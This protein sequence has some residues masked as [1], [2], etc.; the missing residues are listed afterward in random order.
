MLLETGEGADVTFK[1]EE[2]IFHAHKI[3]LGIRSPVFRAELYGL[4]GEQNREHITIEDMQPAIF[5]ALLYFMYTDSLPEVDNL[6]GDESEEMVKHLLVAAH[7]YGVDR[8][9]VMCE[10]ILAKRLDV[11][12]VAATLALADQYHCSELRDSCIEFINSL[13]R[14]EDL[15]ASQGYAHLKRA[16]PDIIVYGRK[17]PN[18]TRHIVC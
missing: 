5:K 6:G 2:E 12:S 9:K 7:R 10:S 15:Q 18:P 13:N 8:M 4:L 16:C 3:V 17:E 11:K 1:V 14:T